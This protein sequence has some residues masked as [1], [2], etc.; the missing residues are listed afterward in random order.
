MKN[1][2]FIFI[3]ALIVFLDIVV[4]RNVCNEPS[5]LVEYNVIVSNFTENQKLEFDYGRNNYVV[6]YNQTLS[7]SKVH[8]EIKETIKYGHYY[9][10]IDGEY[11]LTDINIS[12]IE[13]L[14]ISKSDKKISFP[15]QLKKSYFKKE[16]GKCILTLD[17]IVELEYETIS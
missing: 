3:T 11:V 7:E 13:I 8:Y 9:E 17:V 15:Y 1:I 10:L 4:T 16:N 12:N 6:K 5:Y 14:D 2:R